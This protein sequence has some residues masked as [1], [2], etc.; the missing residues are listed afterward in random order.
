MKKQRNID[1]IKELQAENHGLRE[2]MAAGERRRRAA[3]EEIGFLNRKLSAILA[4]RSAILANHQATVIRMAKKFGAQVGE[5]AW[6]LTYQAADPADLPAH[7]I[8]ASMGEDGVLTV[9]VIEDLEEDPEMGR[10]GESIGATRPWNSLDALEEPRPPHTCDPPEVM[11][12]C[13]SCTREHCPGDCKER[14][15]AAKLASPNTGAGVKKNIRVEDVVAVYE[16][17]GGRLTETAK[18]LGLAKSTVRYWLKKV[19]RIK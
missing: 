17:M 15:R 7:K 11:E 18:Q 14:R 13:V 2:K 6:E 9:R 10:T 4:D 8:E 1:R 12:V 5:N 16:Q 3:V 19:G